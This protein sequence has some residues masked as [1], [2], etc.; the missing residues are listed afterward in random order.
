MLFAASTCKSVR[1]EW[2]GIRFSLM[3]C[4]RRRLSKM[5]NYVIAG[6]RYDLRPPLCED[7]DRSGACPFEVDMRDNRNVKCDTKC[8]LSHRE[9]RI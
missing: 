5:L 6:R 3:K 2:N 9:G 8:L 7:P 1:G 4:L